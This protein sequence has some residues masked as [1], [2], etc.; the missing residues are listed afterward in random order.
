MDAIDKLRVEAVFITPEDRLPEFYAATR[1]K[2]AELY[3]CHLERVLKD[4]IKKQTK[5]NERNKHR[6]LFVQQQQ[7]QQYIQMPLFPVLLPIG[8]DFSS[9]IYP[10]FSQQQQQ[11][12][13]QPEEPAPITMETMND[14]MNSWFIPSQP[15]TTVVPVEEV[16]FFYLF[17][18]FQSVINSEKTPVVLVSKE[19]EERYE[20]AKRITAGPEKQQ[21]MWDFIRQDPLDLSIGKR[22]LLLEEWIA[23]QEKV[24]FLCLSPFSPLFFFLNN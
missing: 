5:L 23:R 8:Q 3:P 4:W 15:T 2:Q 6:S 24:L 17:Y 1:D 18:S 11:Q 21:E 20:Y 13:Q 22:E 19:F 16:D 10:S 9:T 14:L 12:Q 7:Q